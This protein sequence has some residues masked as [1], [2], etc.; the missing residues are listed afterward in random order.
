MAEITKPIILDE[1]GQRIANAIE[2]LGGGYTRAEIDQ[3]LSVKANDAD[4]VHTATDE[5]ISGDKS[6]TGNVTATTQPSGDSSNKIAT[7]EFV[8]DAV[9]DAAF[10]GEDVGSATTPDFNTEVEVTHL[11]S[12]VSA[13]Q[14]AYEA[15]TKSNIVVVESANWP[16]PTL[17]ENTIYRVTG[18]N[19]Y[20]DYMYNGTTTV[21]MATYNN[22]L[23]AVPTEGSTN[24]VQSGGVY[25]AINTPITESLEFSFNGYIKADGTYANTSNFKATDYIGVNV[26]DV[27]TYSLAQGT[28]LPTIAAYNSDKTFIQSLAMGTNGFQTDAKLTIPST[29]TGIA[30][31]RVSGRSTNHDTHPTANPSGTLTQF[32]GVVHKSAFED[33][34]SEEDEIEMYSVNGYMKTDTMVFTSTN[35][36]RMS[37]LIPIYPGYSIKSNSSYSY[38]YSGYVGSVFYDGNATSP[39]STPVAIAPVVNGNITITQEQFELGYRYLSIPFKLETTPSPE[40]VVKKEIKQ[41][42]GRLN[43]DSAESKEALDNYKDSDNITIHKNSGTVFNVYVPSRGGKIVRYYF[44]KYYKKW[45]SL[46]YIDGQGQTQTKTNFVSSDV[47]SNRSVYNAD[48]NTYIC[49]GNDNFIFKIDGEPNHTGETHGCE[50]MKYCSFLAD[51]VEVDPTTLTKDL[52]CKVFECIRRSECYE[53]DGSGNSFSTTYP[54]FDTTGNPIVT[55][56]HYIKITFNIGNEVTID[57]RLEIKRDNIQFVQCHAAMLE[58]NFGDFSRVSVNNTD[59]TINSVSDSGTFALLG[60]S[61]V[62]LGSTNN[63]VATLGEMY[64]KGFTISQEIQPHNPYRIDKCNINVAKYVDRLKLYFMPVGTT[65]SSSVVPAE[66]F[67][68][69]DALQIHCRRIIR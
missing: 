59:S 40:V 12:E 35:S 60:N 23:D 51:G 16:I 19:T 57:N 38:P 9:E 18:T 15:L 54:V 48:D 63:I 33:A 24:P 34:M 3:K 13:L 30:Y 22:G 25:N 58:C 26:G 21:H 46:T 41:M 27:I 56:N 52:K 31:I 6:F 68:S 49:Q 44:E 29:P 64:G 39:E 14:S 11:K 17:E 43:S 67:N 36:F 20:S 8:N 4:V 62:D 2:G 1:T 61:S 42:I 37:N 10:L 53:T 66:T 45:D 28:N 65:T 50:V 5:T 55:A 7:T 32:D 47:W 69:G